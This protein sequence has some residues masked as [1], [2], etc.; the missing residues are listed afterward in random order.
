LSFQVYVYINEVNQKAYVG[1]TCLSLPERARTDGKGYKRCVLFYRA[2]QKYGWCS[3][4]PL[5]IK[6]N[7]SLEEA[8]RMER[9]Y[10]TLLKSNDPAFGY[11]LKDG[12]SRGLHSESSKKKVSDAKKGVPKTEDHKRKL[13][14]ASKGNTSHKGFKH[15]PE[16]RAKMSTNKGKTWKL[17]DGKRVWFD[18]PLEQIME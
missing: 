8:D 2:I 16:V 17:I 9:E 10:I 12:G 15:S 18:K 5:T 14:E 11:N 7:L 13:A 4:L 3:F 6:D 1:Q